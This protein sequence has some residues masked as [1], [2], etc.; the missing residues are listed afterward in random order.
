MCGAVQDRMGKMAFFKDATGCAD[1][2]QKR[3]SETAAEKMAFFHGYGG[4]ALMAEIFI[5]ELFFCPLRH[6]HS[7]LFRLL[8]R[9]Y[10][11]PADKDRSVH[12]FSKHPAAVLL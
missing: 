10:N 7:P 11:S 1:F 9:I 3:L 6:I 8:Q 12:T 2:L 5:D 4:K